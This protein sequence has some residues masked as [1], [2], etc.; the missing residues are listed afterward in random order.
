MKNYLIGLL[1]G[2]LGMVAI[3]AVTNSSPMFQSYPRYMFKRYPVGGNIWEHG[4]LWDT[5][6]GFAWQVESV[7]DA[8]GGMKAVLSFMDGQ[9]VGPADIAAK[10][11]HQK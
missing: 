10:V 11:T 8:N 1:I 3:G 2:V 7:K 6:T 9:G 5:E 4:I